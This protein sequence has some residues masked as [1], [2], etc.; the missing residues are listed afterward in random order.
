[1]KTPDGV[2]IR[3]ATNQD[4]PAIRAVLLSVRSEFAVMDDTGVSD[5]DLNDVEQNYFGSGGVFEV[6]E[7]R[8]SNRIVGCAGLLPRSQCR[9]ELCK[10]YILK[11]ARGQGLGKR[12]LEDLLEAARRGGFAE[13]WLETNSVLTAAT[14]LYE[15]YGFQPVAPDHLSPRCD[16]AYLL[17][18]T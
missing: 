14:S 3:R 10:M 4:L 7:D 18:L 17:R 8:R 6:I 2:T 9:V 11:S 16:Q 15:T 13:V 5:Q 12:L 1:M